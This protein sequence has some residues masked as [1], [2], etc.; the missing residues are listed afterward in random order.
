M[1]EFKAAEDYERKL[2]E[3]KAN[4]RE[5]REKYFA[6]GM[7]V[8]LGYDPPKPTKEEM[9]SIIAREK[10]RKHDEYN[11]QREIELKIF[12]IAGLVVL[13]VVVVLLMMALKTA[14]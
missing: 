12:K 14:V 7:K 2:E 5:T 11:K 8:T 10:K 4:H 1:S 3:Y 13:A 6:R 9:A